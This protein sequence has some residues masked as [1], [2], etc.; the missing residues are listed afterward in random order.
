MAANQLVYGEVLMP[1]EIFNQVVP[2][3]DEAAFDQVPDDG[4]RADTNPEGEGDQSR[5]AD[6]RR[7]IMAYT[8][9]TVWSDK[10][11]F[12]DE[13]TGW[14]RIEMPASEFVDVLAD[15]YSPDSLRELGLLEHVGDELRLAGCPDGEGELR[16]KFDDEQCP[17]RF[18]TAS[19][20]LFPL[21]H[22]AIDYAR[23]RIATD[24]GEQTTALYVVETEESADLIRQLRLPSVT[25]QGLEQLD[26]H[27][28]QDLF[29][30]N[31]RS[32]LDWRY[33]LVLVDFDIETL[34]NQPVPSVAGVVKRLNHAASVYQID[35]ARRFA[36]CRPSTSDFEMLELAVDFADRDR[37]RHL[38]DAWSNAAREISFVNWPNHAITKPS[39]IANARS[40]LRRLLESPHASLLQ[41]KLRAALTEYRCAGKDAIIEKLSAAA[42]STE[43]PFEQVD[44]ISAV[45]YAEIIFEH[46]LLVRRAEAVLA[47][48]RIE[49][50]EEL[51]ES[52]IRMV[53]KSIN[54]VRRI[55]QTWRRR[56]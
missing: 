56:R 12:L 46:D 36:V 19:E 5:I 38:F 18:T 39:S 48:R 45:R 35:P 40:A 43:N 11:A 13:Q 41:N 2:S 29:S 37:I 22:S 14:H 1:E 24:S 33:F 10:W 7:V 49:H 21:S 31:R 9:S 16:V 6:L 15:H 47:G 3:A 51:D 25:S 54:E 42:D 26:R 8:V 4:A 17:I 52:T 27:Q 50:T 55:G 30:G 44:M 32:D 34:T 53:Q 23:Q 20:F 28:I